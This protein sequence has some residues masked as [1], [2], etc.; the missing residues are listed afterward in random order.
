MEPVQRPNGGRVLDLV[1]GGGL[2]VLFGL[3]V[4]LTTTPV[5]ASILASLVA[6]A[7][8]FVGLSE[9]VPAG[10]SPATPLR[11]AVFSLCAAIFVLAGIYVRAHGLLSPS[12]ASI[13]RE[14]TEAGFDPEE[15]KHMVRLRL[16]GVL[17][18]GA[19]TVA[20]DNLGGRVAASTLF[21]GNAENCR[22]LLQDRRLDQPQRIASLLEMEQPFRGVGERLQNAAPERRG[23]LLDAA[24]FYLCD[25]R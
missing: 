6:L 14:L 22:R 4:G 3:L 20:P 2:G 8:A 13:A 16:F 11:L 18:E 1:A 5:V 25:L 7:V 9:S 19:T 23:P 21:S 10:V 12:P 15:A 24:E 17:P